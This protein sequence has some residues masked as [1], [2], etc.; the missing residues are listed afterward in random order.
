[1]G[2]EPIKPTAGIF[3]IQPGCV[4]L[5]TRLGRVVLAQRSNTS[6]CWGV[7]FPSRMLLIYVVNVVV[8]INPW[9][10]NIVYK[11]VDIVLINDLLFLIIFVAITDGVFLYKTYLCE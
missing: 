4:L 3:I 10:V 6:C 1:M 11:V 2:G 8:N 7:L 5:K 9:I